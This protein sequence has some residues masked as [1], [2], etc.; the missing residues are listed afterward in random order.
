M[1]RKHLPFRFKFLNYYAYF[2][3][4]QTSRHS[5]LN[6]DDRKVRIESSAE[7]TDLTSVESYI[8]RF[9]G[10]GAIDPALSDFPT[11]VWR[12]QR[13]AMLGKYSR[14]SEEI[15]AIWVRAF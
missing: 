5:P 6:G 13:S 7:S 12:Y 1:A 10:K 4:R 9:Q 2:P 15:V 11:I 8:G 3:K 14:T